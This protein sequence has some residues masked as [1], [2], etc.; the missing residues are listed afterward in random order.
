VGLCGLAYDHREVVILRRLSTNTPSPRVL[1]LYD[2]AESRE[3]LSEAFDEIAFSL[4]LRDRQALPTE[5]LARLAGFV[6]VVVEVSSAQDAT[7]LVGALRVASNVPL[8]AVGTQLADLHA[9]LAAG[10]DDYALI[11][12]PEHLA[13]LVERVQARVAA[14]KT[15]ARGERPNGQVLLDLTRALVSSLDFQEILYMLVSRIAQ[16]IEVDRVSIVLA[17]DESQVGYVVAASDD[18]KLRNLRI[19]LAKYPEIKHVLRTRVPLTVEDVDNHP[20]LDELRRS[21]AYAGLTALTLIPIVSEGSAMGVIFIRART[22][23]G[24]L[25]PE[26]LQFCETLANATAVALRNARIL[27]TLR[28]ES[29]R[30]VYARIEAEKRLSALTRYADLLTSSA[31]GI[32]AF[33]RG[34]YLIFANPSAAR[35]LGYN[36]D[37]YLG[38]PMWELVPPAQRKAMRSLRRRL[39]SGQFPHDVDIHMLHHSGEPL[40][41]NGSFAP[42]GGTEGAVLLSFRDVSQDRKTRDELVKTRNFLQSLIDASV[43]AIVAA[44]MNGTIILFNQGAQELYGYAAQD[45]IGR[46]NARK[47]YPGDGAREVMRMLRAS[48]LGGPGRLEP[49]RIEAVDSSGHIFPISLTAAF[50]YEN[51]KPTA[52]FGIFT[53]LRERVRVEQQLA[54]AQEQLA[55][56]EKQSLLAELAGATAHELNQPLTSVMGYAELLTRRAAQDSSVSRAASYIHQEASRM[57]EIVRKIGQLTRYE[58]K[59]YVGDQRILDLDRGSG[60]E[61]EKAEPKS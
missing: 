53:D 14:N 52:S 44:T 30:D 15:R 21:V 61:P 38:R 19:N 24:A 41:I 36:A 22:H 3:A 58:T 42:L 10:A 48:G 7:S 39:A 56:S 33:D 32:A 57:A 23:R 40:I 28:D 20:L 54:Q 2:R 27:Q 9:A 1:V 16:S 46:M 49:V 60:G 17:P 4:E 43:D 50:I 35:I 5:A 26:Q 13:Q 37:V 34:G 45:V 59:S 25:N 12:S 6:A 47:L 11:D 29:Q 31:D 18:H 55:M 8:V 51:G